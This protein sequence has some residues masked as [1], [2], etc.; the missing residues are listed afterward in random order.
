M[1]PNFWFSL[2]C[3]QTTCSYD[4]LDQGGIPWNRALGTRRKER[5]TKWRVRSKEVLAWVSDKKFL[6]LMNRFIQSLFRLWFRSR[7]REVVMERLLIV[8]AIMKRLL[9]VEAIGLI[10]I[11]TGIVVMAQQIPWQTASSL[12]AGVEV[13]L[14]VMCMNS[15]IRSTWRLKRRG[16][17]GEHPNREKGNG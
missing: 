13:C 8:D 16:K 14:R 9:I 1:N 7:C 4:L 11:L 10:V 5:F 3:W 2:A 6:V 15:Q 12:S 17:V